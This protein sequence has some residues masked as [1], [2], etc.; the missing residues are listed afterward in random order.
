MFPTG[1]FNQRL[2]N[3]LPEADQAELTQERLDSEIQFLK[4]SHFHLTSIKLLL[5][6]YKLLNYWAFPPNT[7]D[8]FCSWLMSEQTTATSSEI[9]VVLLQDIR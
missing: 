9:P 2:R 5:L 3:K 7:C 6:N 4:L 1:I 8:H